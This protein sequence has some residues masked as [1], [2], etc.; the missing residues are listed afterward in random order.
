MESNEKTPGREPNLSVDDLLI[1]E[2]DK[3]IELGVPIVNGD[4][5]NDY[6]ATICINSS[7]CSEGNGSGCS[8]G[9]SCS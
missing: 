7:R 8:N 4:I 9:G 1:I 3:R 2:L 6:N 5:D